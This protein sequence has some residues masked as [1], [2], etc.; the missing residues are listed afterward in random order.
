MGFLQQS[1]FCMATD[2]R[3]EALDRGTGGGRST[4]TSVARG[5]RERLSDKTR[6]ADAPQHLRACH[7]AREAP[8][9]AWPTSPRA[10]LP[11]PSSSRSCSVH[12]GATRRRARSARTSCRGALRLCARRTRT[13]RCTRLARSSMGGTSVG[14]APA[15]SCHPDSRSVHLTTG[16]VSEGCS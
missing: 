3:E 10:R 6:G 2:F 15:R 11:T 9:R 12:A 7:C 1:T 8:T 5:L 16:F 4:M 14:S 13:G